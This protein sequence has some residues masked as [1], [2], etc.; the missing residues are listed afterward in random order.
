MKTYT[1]QKMTLRISDNL[2]LLGCDSRVAIFQWPRRWIYFEAMLSCQEDGGLLECFKEHGKAVNK[3]ASTQ[4]KATHERR[5]KDGSIAC[6]TVA[7]EAFERGEELE[8]HRARSPFT[9]DKIHF[10]TIDASDE[11]ND[12][13][14]YPIK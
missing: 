2:G 6:V 12:W 7:Q 8:A 5:R 14:R 9:A 13:V 4:T 1:Y 10:I 11:V 3:G